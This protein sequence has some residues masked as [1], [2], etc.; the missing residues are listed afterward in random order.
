MID[1]SGFVSTVL[2]TPHTRYGGALSPF[3][4]GIARGSDGAL[5]VTD[6]DYD[7]IVRVTRDGEVSIVADLGFTRPLGII[8][9][10]DGD[11]LVSDSGVIWKITLGDGT[12]TAAE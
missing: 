1:G 10:A 12:G 11:L 6:H 5:Y 7:R 4:G 8:V 3:L 9:T 2:R